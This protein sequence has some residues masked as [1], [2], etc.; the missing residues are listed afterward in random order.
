MPT[1]SDFLR[2]LRDDPRSVSAPTPS[3]PALA[4]AIAAQVNPQRPGLVVELGAGTGTVTAALIHHGISPARLVLFESI[5][6][7]HQLLSRQFPGVKIFCADAFQFDSFLPAGVPI[8]AVISGL[9]LLN[10]PAARRAQLIETALDRQG[11]GGQ[12]VQLSYGWW[13]PIP[14]GPSLSLSKLTVWR[15][16]PPAHVWIY[17]RRH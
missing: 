1:Y 15:N 9:P 7:F 17:R 3:G 14:P 11:L 4:R 8:A 5:P 16:L 13:P 6:N 12:F 2:G 10:H